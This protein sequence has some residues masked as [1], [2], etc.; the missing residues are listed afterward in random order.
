MGAGEE[1]K[2]SDICRIMH[3]LSGCILPQGNWGGGEGRPPDFRNKANLCGVD[4][5]NIT[6]VKGN[7]GDEFHKFMPFNTQWLI[8]FNLWSTPSKANPK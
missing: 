3:T 4:V 1:L 8:H 6:F 7:F 5:Y 2:H